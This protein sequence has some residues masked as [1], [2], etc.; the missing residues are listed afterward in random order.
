MNQ[1]KCDVLVIGG[2]ISGIIA[3][4]SA[5]KAGAD[6]IL[7]ES[8]P[9]LGGDAISG[10]V[11]DACLNAKGQWIIGGVPRELFQLCE[12]FDGYVGPVFDWRLMWGVG[13]D[14]EIVKLSII[15][16]LAKY[17]VRTMLYTYAHDVVMHGGKVAGVLTMGKSGDHLIT[18]KMVIDCSGDGDIACKAG[19]KFEFGVQGKQ[20]QPITLIYTMGNIDSEKFLQFAVDHPEACI[21]GESPVN[22]LTPEECA[23]E[24]Y[25]AGYPCVALNGKSKFLLDAAEQGKMITCGAVYTF[26]TSLK[27]R[28]VVIN[29]TRVANVNALNH[30]AISDSIYDLTEQ[31]LL[32]TSFLKGNVPGFEEAY[33][34]MISPRLGIRETRRIMGDYVLTDDDVIKAKKRPDVVAKGGH[35]IDVHG[36]GSDQIRIPVENGGSYDIPLGSMTIP[37]F[38][39][40]MMAGRCFSS[41]RGANGSARMMG[42]CMAMGQA[43]GVAAAMCTKDGIGDIHGVSIGNLQD[44]LRG[45]GAVLDGV[46]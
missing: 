35:H 39:N 15:R 18:P 25:K 4:A 46:L 7:V 1:E 41:Q 20:F 21:L 8:G 9:V 12:Q 16:L 37:G 17:K 31:L 26:P 11:I 38:E 27:K 30:D 40:L 19:A 42:T 2:G 28:E 10:M 13:V 14:P 3:A 34:G 43:T 29:A 45:M 22:D 33:I 24:M 44:T 6:T 32:C 36:A 23:R 5:A